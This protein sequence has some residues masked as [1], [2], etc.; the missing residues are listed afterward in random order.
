MPT[1]NLIIYNDLNLTKE[2]DFGPCRHHR[3]LFNFNTKGDTENSRHYNSL[4]NTVNFR[5][6]I[7]IRQSFAA[8]VNKLQSLEILDQFHARI[9]LHIKRNCY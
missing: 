5:R 8:T 1:A 7:P 4:N 6:A 2:F 3:F 9:V